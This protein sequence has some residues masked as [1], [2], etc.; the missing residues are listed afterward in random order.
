MLSTP[1]VKVY[2]NITGKDVMEGLEGDAGQWIADIMAKQAK[3]PV[4]WQET[5]ENMA[6]DGI[7]VF[8]KLDWEIPSGGLAK[9]IN[10]EF[11]TMH[12]ENYETLIE[13]R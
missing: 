7:N 1:T 6:A 8:I 11:V 10:H 3:S 13:K 9:K 12:V 4:F 5:M 2:S